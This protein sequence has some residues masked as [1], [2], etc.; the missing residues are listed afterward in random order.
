MKI[1]LT[2]LLVFIS[3]FQWNYEFVLAI[4]GRCYLCTENGLPECLG[5]DDPNSPIFTNVLK[6]YTEPCNGQCVLFRDPSGKT[7]R[8]C[9]W[10]YGHMQ[11]RTDG[12][13]EITPGILSYFCD[14]NLCN[15]GILKDLQWITTTTTIPTTTTTTTITTTTTTMMMNMFMNDL[16]VVPPM[17]AFWPRRI[18]QCYTCTERLRGCGEYLDPRYASNY[19]RPCLASCMIFRN[20]SD[21]DG[22]NVWP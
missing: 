21:D 18:Q 6:Y 1:R 22:K 15:G 3:V 10:T 17:P 13:Y 5:S 9:S 12:W 8:G 4:A 16:N 11:Q 20:P 19:I 2:S 7:I 14:S